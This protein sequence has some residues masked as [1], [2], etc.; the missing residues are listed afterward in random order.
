MDRRLEFVSFFRK[1]GGTN[2]GL[3]RCAILDANSTS[4]KRA[5]AIGP[6]IGICSAKQR[7]TNTEINTE[8]M[9]RC[10]AAALGDKLILL[11][12]PV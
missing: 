4:A 2:N 6:I 9:A 11:M 12:K 8:W 1:A 10:N 5:P 3:E 7:G